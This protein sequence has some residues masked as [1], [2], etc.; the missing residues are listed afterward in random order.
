MEK[1]KIQATGSAYADTVYDD[2]DTLQMFPIG[3]FI[4]PAEALDLDDDGTYEIVWA[5]YIELPYDLEY[6]K[7]NGYNVD[8]L[9]D[10]DIE[11]FCYDNELDT[12]DYINWDEF[13]VYRDGKNVTEKVEVIRNQY[14]A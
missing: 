4:A 10:M 14:F 2:M 13:S 1:N 3:G 7:A 12:A 9:A 5:N 8:A 11:Q 6:Y